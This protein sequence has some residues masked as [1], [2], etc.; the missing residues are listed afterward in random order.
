MAQRRI[1]TAHGMCLCAGENMYEWGVA[2]PRIGTVCGID[3]LVCCTCRVGVAS[4]ESTFEL[5]TVGQKDVRDGDLWVV[6]QYMSPVCEG[7]ALD[8]RVH[9]ERNEGLTVVVVCSALDLSNSEALLSVR[10]HQSL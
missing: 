7:R 3:Q 5:V 8:E 1:G 4:F 6:V 9:D 10:V 2:R